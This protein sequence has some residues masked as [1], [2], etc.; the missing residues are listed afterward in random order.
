MPVHEVLPT[1][2]LNSYG[3]ERFMFGDRWRFGIECEVQ[4][5]ELD[6]WGS[7]EPYGSLWLWG[8]PDS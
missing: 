5:C 6:P 3:S 7:P 4:N 1:P 8:G 2:D